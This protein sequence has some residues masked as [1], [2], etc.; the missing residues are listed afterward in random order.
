MDSILDGIKKEK[1]EFEKDDKNK[2]KITDVSLDTI[3][4]C[5]KAEKKL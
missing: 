1:E 5:E 2:I 4:E 3:E